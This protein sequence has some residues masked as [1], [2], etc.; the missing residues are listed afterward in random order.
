MIGLIFLLAVILV[1]AGIAGWVDPR[2]A[3]DRRN[4]RIYLWVPWR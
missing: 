3:S 2:S 4:R 1:L